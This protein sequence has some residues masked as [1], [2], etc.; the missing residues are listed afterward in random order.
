VESWLPFRGKTLS[1]GE[2]GPS[3]EVADQKYNY[4]GRS[5][6]N[7]QSKSSGLQVN[8]SYFNHWF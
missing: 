3:S 4:L 2:G 7:Q 8:P 1:I 5:F 6:I